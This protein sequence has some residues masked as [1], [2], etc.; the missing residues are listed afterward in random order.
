MFLI[1]AATLYL[2]FSIFSPSKTA[3]M[4]SLVIYT[5]IMFV[6]LISAICDNQKERQYLKIIDEMNN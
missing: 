6:T 2:V 1:G 3:Y 4:E 5:G